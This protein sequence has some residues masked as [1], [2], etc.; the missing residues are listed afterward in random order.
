MTAQT[1]QPAGAPAER[2][3]SRPEVLYILSASYSGST[4]L[5][6]LLARHPEI[7]TI[8]ELKAQ[9]MGDVGRYVCSCGAAIRQCPFWETVGER[10]K[11]RGREFDLA[12]FGTHFG[13][14]GRWLSDRLLRASYRGSAFESAR[15]IGLRAV[16]SARKRL[17]SVLRQNR[18]LIEVVNEIQAGRVFLDGSKDAIRLHHMFEAGIWPIK[19]VHLVR[20]GRGAANS[21]AK[22]HQTGM[23]A[24][25]PEWVGEQAEEQRLLAS[26]P[27]EA[28]TRVNYEDLC[29]DPDRTLKEIFRFAACDPDVPGIL[30]SACEHHIVGNRMR[31]KPLEKITYDEKWRGEL[32]EEDLVVFN[33]IAGDMNRQYG[34]V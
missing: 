11:A 15:S 9:A 18:A 17:A 6:I 19:V 21:Y 2:Q 22:H 32:T 10:M 14:P 1:V 24:A 16:P 28:W 20:D 12:D 4:L 25:A 8:G 7:A 23:G 27:P 29:R 26:L 5:T 31:L 33:R 34:Y 13:A 3:P 30:E